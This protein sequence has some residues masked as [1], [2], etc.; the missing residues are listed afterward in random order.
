MHCSPGNYSR[1]PTYIQQPLD[2][3]RRKKKNRGHVMQS[4]ALLLPL[5]RMGHTRG[6]AI[7]A[8]DIKDGALD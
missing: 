2:N 6:R 8:C 1:I 4:R 3:A 5:L 7:D